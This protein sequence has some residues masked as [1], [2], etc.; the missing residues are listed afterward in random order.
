MLDLEIIEC[1]IGTNG[2]LNRKLDG[3]IFKVEK[4]ST[5]GHRI[6][7]PRGTQGNVPNSILHVIEGLINA[8]ET[9]GV[10]RCDITNKKPGHAN[11]P[12]NEYELE[13]RTP[14]EWELIGGIKHG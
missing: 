13:G 8:G 6:W 12:T 2:E 1:W 10:I 9:S 3:H 7:Q 11:P 14:Y 4:H 5:G